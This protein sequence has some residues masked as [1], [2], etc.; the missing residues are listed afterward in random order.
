MGLRVTYPNEGVYAGGKPRL[1]QFDDKTGQITYARE[2][3]VGEAAVFANTEA[4]HDLRFALE[5]GAQQ[6]RD[7]MTYGLPK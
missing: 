4:M 1:E 2:A 6:L 5:Q 3:T 7:V